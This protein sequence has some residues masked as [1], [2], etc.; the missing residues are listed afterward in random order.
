MGQGRIDSG[1]RSLGDGRG[2]D[3]GSMV[4]EPG[5]A[6]GSFGSGA[7]AAR[8]RQINFV[9]IIARAPLLERALLVGNSMLLYW[10]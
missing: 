9:I 7:R 2:R 1:F 3:P 5:K 6:T 4:P 10:A 8:C